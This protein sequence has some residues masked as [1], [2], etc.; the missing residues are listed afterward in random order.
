MGSGFY[1]FN[2]EIGEMYFF[3]DWEKTSYIP[4][5]TDTVDKPDSRQH[6]EKIKHIIEET[7][8]GSFI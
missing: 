1:C 6:V 4:K 3:G 2:S 5:F 7:F 8:M